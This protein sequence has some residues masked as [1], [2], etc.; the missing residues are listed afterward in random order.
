MRRRGETSAKAK[1]KPSPRRDGQGCAVCGGPVR[2]ELVRVSQDKGVT[3]FTRRVLRC[4]RLGVAGAPACP[5]LCEDEA[6]R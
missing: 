2:I 6:L 3:W 5:A 4:S 1:P